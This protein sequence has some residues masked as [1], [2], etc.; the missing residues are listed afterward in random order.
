MSQE[1]ITKLAVRQK[2]SDLDIRYDVYK[3]I[4]G[5]LGHDSTRL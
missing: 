5:E 3:E 4:I 1:E 2:S